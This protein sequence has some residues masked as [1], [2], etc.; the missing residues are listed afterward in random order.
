MTH[1]A[2]P[3]TNTFPTSREMSSKNKDVTIVNFLF[4]KKK[5]E[6]SKEKEKEKFSISPGEVAKKR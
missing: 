5:K 1:V 2:L 6:E 4:K 3:V